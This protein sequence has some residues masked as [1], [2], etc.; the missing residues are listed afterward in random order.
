MQRKMTMTEENRN[1]RSESENPNVRV[2][3]EKEH[4]GIGQ[5]PCFF[6]PY[7]ERLVQVFEPDTKGEEEVVEMINEHW[8]ATIEELEEIAKVELSQGYSG[9]HIRN[10]LRSHFIPEDPMHTEQPHLLDEEV[11]DSTSGGEEIAV[12]DEDWHKIFRVGIRAALQSD[13]GEE[14]AFE[15]FGSGFV[16]GK[17]LQNEMGSENKT[18]LFS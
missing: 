17:K 8:P 9:S 1:G 4:K 2:E 6:A 15:A 12:Q 13:V 16:E 18:R 3:T 5:A 10:V 11:V 7:P 14:E